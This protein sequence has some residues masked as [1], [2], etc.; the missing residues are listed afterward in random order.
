VN[1]RVTFNHR[2]YCFQ[3][4]LISCPS[5]HLRHTAV[6]SWFISC[7]NPLISSK[8]VLHLNLQN[9]SVKINELGIYNT[10]THTLPSKEFNAFHFIIAIQT[11]IT[12]GWKVQF[13]MVP[14]H[15]CQTNVT[16]VTNM[17]IKW[18]PQGAVIIVTKP[19]VL[20]WFDVCACVCVTRHVCVFTWL[21]VCV[22]LLDLSHLQRWNIT[23]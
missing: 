17:P 4:T 13:S 21:I 6:K 3:K 15:H 22:C 5:H 11:K 7:W 1:I 18:S 23:V 10:H 9:L 20:M 2:Y 16:M 12:Y 19:V 8:P 14:L